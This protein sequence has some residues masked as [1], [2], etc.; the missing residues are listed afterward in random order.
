MQSPRTDD[1]TRNVPWIGAPSRLHE[2]QSLIVIGLGGFGRYVLHI[3]SQEFAR[4]HVPK[5][6]RYFA[7]F[8]SDASRHPSAGAPADHDHL[9]RL[10]PFDRQTYVEKSAPE[11]QDAL[12]HL[13]AR[14]LRDDPARPAALPSRGFVTFHRYDENTITRHAIGLIEA[15]RADNPTGRVKCIVVYSM[16]GGFAG[17][18]A[19]PFLFRVQERLRHCK[20]RLE[21]FLVT[22]EPYRGVEN[23]PIRQVEDNCVAHAMLW[24]RVLRADGDIVYPGK[25]GVRETRR[26][27]GPLPHR[28]WI[29]SGG[30]GPAQYSY[31]V[32][33]SIVANCIATLELTRLGSY[34]DGDRV[35]YG[36]D[37]LE[38]R[39]VG[40]T[41]AEHPTSLLAMNV[42][43]LKADSLP[44]LF[45]LRSARRF[46]GSVTQALSPESEER[47]R[48]TAVG[49]LVDTGINDPDILEELEVGRN[50][51]TREV[52]EQA[53]PRDEDAYAFMRE[54]LDLDLGV[55]YELADGKSTPEKT[56]DVIRRA[57]SAISNRARRIADGPQGYLPGAVLYYRTVQQ[58]LATQH[59]EC[60]ERLT[61][62]RRE[63][64]ASR[65]RE[66]LERLLK[67][68]KQDT[69]RDPNHKPNMFERFVSTITVSVSTQ[70]RKIV[71]V[72]DAVREL[73][74]A[75]GSNGILTTVYARLAR[76]CESECERLQ[77][78]AYALNNVMARCA[79]EE[80]MVQR[81]SRGAFVYQKARFGALVEGLCD[82]L[83]TEL[84]SADAPEVIEKL[85]GLLGLG[86]NETEMFQRILNAV[87][88]DER[89]LLDATDRIMAREPL[90]I[91]ALKESLTQFVAT[92]R[93]DHERFGELDTV[94]S[95]YV[96]CT[97]RMYEAHEHDLFQDYHHL[98]TENPYNVLF[99]EHHEGLPFLAVRYMGEIN[100]RY[101]AEPQNERHKA[102]SLA[103]LAHDLP[104]L[105]A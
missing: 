65:D 2:D 7:A 38:R 98:E 103:A 21:A 19:V 88:P 44:A 36:E 104:P 89:R 20:V 77:S 58:H 31:P 30:S 63:L 4:L 24:E 50:T 70:M 61:H 23:V 56:E 9:V 11:L 102:H 43:G 48:E 68:L 105:D 16:G 52:V 67:R 92:I 41:D 37:V 73:A 40:P 83:A 28:T 18:M 96:L 85:D 1:A 22:S 76:F 87:R 27:R 42:A 79:R 35:H 78:T 93:F 95:R 57:K 97:K 10:E 99:T 49:S 71:E 62:A 46:V 53:K 47:V 100:A 90:V 51:L 29:F 82:R 17:G 3:L 14:S 32:V 45:H 84:E 15:A 25:P 81:V 39:W 64:D 80:E 33:A 74:Y 13:E 60:A 12:S 26:F 55:L 69:R 94:R 6:R 54:R 75:A 5:N 72:A 91:D 34:L 66:R 8:D 86:A 101:R 59:R